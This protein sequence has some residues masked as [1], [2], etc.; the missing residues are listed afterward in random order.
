MRA[1]MNEAAKKTLLRHVP[2]GLYVIG[3]GR[4]DEANAFTASWLTQ[5]SMRPPVIALGIRE[6]SESL[7]RARAGGCLTVNFFGK[8][9]QDTLLFFIKP[10]K[11]EHHRLMQYPFHPA[12]NGAPVLQGAI[13]HLECEIRHVVGGF[14][15]HALLI[16][17][18]T[19]AALL[20]DAPPL[21]MSD[22]PWHYGG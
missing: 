2:Y 9:A 20:S 16:A 21:V 5:I 7:R 19:D 22:T 15:D 10:V 3:V 6:G 12:A 4:G 13:G 18:V 17:E 8:D 11:D 1:I 14:G